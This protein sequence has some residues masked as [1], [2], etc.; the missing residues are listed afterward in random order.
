MIIMNS[1]SK[2]DREYHSHYSMYLY[3]DANQR[4]IPVSNSNRTNVAL[5][6]SSAD[7]DG[8]TSE[9]QCGLLVF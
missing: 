6:F 9:Y 7:P 5:S 8:T 2:Y 3:H 4:L 1:Q